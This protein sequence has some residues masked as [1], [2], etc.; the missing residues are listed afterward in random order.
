[1]AGVLALVAVVA[2]PRPAVKHAGRIVSGAAIQAEK[3]RRKVEA[4]RAASSGS[5][6]TPAAAA[7]LPVEN[8]EDPLA[9]MVV[10]DAPEDPSVAANFRVH[11]ELVA[12]YWKRL[13]QREDAALEAKCD[14]MISVMIAHD[15][16][17]VHT[18]RLELAVVQRFRERSPDPTTQGLL[19][20]IDNSASTVI[21]HGD[22]RAV[23][24]P[25]SGPK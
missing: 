22:P 2:W 10:V 11:A 12:P 20:Y 5:V 19:D 14:A 3:Q 7:P 9:D 18:A 4:S 8:A 23:P 1:M 21:Q 16:P 15:A 13:C 17:P 24:P 25:G 6:D